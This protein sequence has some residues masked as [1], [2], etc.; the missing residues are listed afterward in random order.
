MLSYANFCRW[1][2]TFYDTKSHEL[3]GAECILMKDSD[4]AK[5]WKFF[6]FA[7]DNIMEITTDEKDIREPLARLL[8]Y[9][10][11]QD[12]EENLLAVSEIL[13]KF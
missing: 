11:P 4:S 2:D 13:A 5:Y 1:T 6:C 10:V 12:I 7:T 3:S 9:D 8:P